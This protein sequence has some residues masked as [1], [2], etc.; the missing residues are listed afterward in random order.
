MRGLEDVYR[1]QSLHVIRVLFI[2]GSTHLSL[3][4]GLAEEQFA[5][6]FLGQGEVGEAVWYRGGNDLFF[7]SW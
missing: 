1:K 6:D 2:R 7:G 4:R 3:V 5:E